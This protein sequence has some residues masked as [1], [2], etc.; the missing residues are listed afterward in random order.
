MGNLIYIYSF[1]ALTDAIEGQFF[2]GLNFYTLS[3]TLLACRAMQLRFLKVETVLN[4]AF[5]SQEQDLLAT[6]ECN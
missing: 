5:K 4:N 6:L 1:E 3:K 2:S